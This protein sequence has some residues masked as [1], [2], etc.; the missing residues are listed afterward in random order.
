MRET[1]FKRLIKINFISI[2]FSVVII[3]LSFFILIY[4]YTYQTRLNLMRSNIYQIIELVDY[5]TIYN[6][7][8][9]NITFRRDLSIISQSMQSYIFITDTNGRIIYSSNSDMTYSSINL[10]IFQ[11]F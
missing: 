8:I 1:I 3:G 6:N 11:R 9:T 7:P 5:K 2:I 10:R 4:S